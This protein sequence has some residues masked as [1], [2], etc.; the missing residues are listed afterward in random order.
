MPLKL[1][2]CTGACSLFKKIEAFDIPADDN[3]RFIKLQKL[4]RRFFCYDYIVNKSGREKFSVY[5]YPA[6]SDSDF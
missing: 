6:V 3:T 2:S 5:T 1:K 4:K